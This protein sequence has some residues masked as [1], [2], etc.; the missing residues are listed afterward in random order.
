MSTY[1]HLVPNLPFPFETKGFSFIYLFSNIF[2]SMVTSKPSNVIPIESF[3]LVINYCNNIKNLSWG[4]NVI[5]KISYFTWILGFIHPNNVISSM[6]FSTMWDIILSLPPA[7]IHGILPLEISH[8]LIVYFVHLYW[9]FL[10]SFDLAF[11]LV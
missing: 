1:L 9:H 5:F 8:P 11:V 3:T 4:Q 10:W 7:H 6:C 2:A